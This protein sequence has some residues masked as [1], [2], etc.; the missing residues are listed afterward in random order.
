MTLTDAYRIAASRG[1]LPSSLS[2]VELRRAYTA[3]VRARAV[4]SARTTHAG[5]LAFL[6]QQIGQLLATENAEG[7]SIGP[8][9][10][11]LRLKQMLAALRYDPEAGGFGTPED[12]GVPP[13]VRG[14]LQDLSSDRRINL[15]IDTQQIR[16]T[17]AGQLER[18]LQPLTL[19]VFPAWELVPGAARE[20]RTNWPQRWM[21]AGGTLYG[22]RENRL[23]AHKN[24][25]VWQRLGELAEYPDTLDG[26]MPPFA[27]GS[28]RVWL[29]VSLRECIALGVDLSDGSSA[30]PAATPAGGPATA[31][32]RLPTP[33]ASVPEGADFKPVAKVLQADLQ[34]GPDGKP[35]LSYNA[36]LERALARRAAETG[37]AN[38]PAA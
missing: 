34:T 10:V 2:S 35:R 3:A 26:G 24:S 13:A 5:Y 28:K 19:K 33:M 20:P 27:F 7:D 32:S 17:S 22:P 36:I 11:R 14:S 31:A 23:I 29:S 12:A 25:P 1:V 30:R 21:A 18:G 37:V 9:E 15:I 8:A 6:K 4:F 38:R 16:Y